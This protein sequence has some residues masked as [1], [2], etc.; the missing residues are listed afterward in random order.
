MGYSNWFHLFRT[1]RYSNE[2]TFCTIS[3]YF[4]ATSHFLHHFWGLW[5][6]FILFLSSKC[7][8]HGTKNFQHNLTVWTQNSAWKT[9]QP[10]W[11]YMQNSCLTLWAKQK[12][13]AKKIESTS[14]VLFSP[15][16]NKFLRWN[17][18]ILPIVFGRMT[19]QRQWNIS[20]IWLK[21]L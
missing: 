9:M 2:Y 10:D 6:N 1:C 4:S 20:K 14:R 12:P 21:C 19:I 13:S 7:S 18:D 11:R 15:F 5:P 17:R 3:S 16:T 8:F